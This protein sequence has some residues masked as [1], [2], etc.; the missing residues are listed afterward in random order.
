KYLGLVLDRKWNF[1]EHFRQLAPRVVG[2]ASAFSRLLP[3]V[4]GPGAPC[5]RLFAGVVRSMATKILHKLVEG[6]S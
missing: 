4:G 1:E 3:N 5:R 2:A 6:S